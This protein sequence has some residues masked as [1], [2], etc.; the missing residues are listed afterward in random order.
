MGEPPLRLEPVV[1]LLKK[2]GDRPLA[3]EF[4][5]DPAVGRLGR[6]GLGS[7]LAELGM[8]TVIDAGPANAPGQSNPLAW[9]TFTSV[10]APRIIPISRASYA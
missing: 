9:L 4:G 5:R 1:G 3:E 10:D 2:P 8:G 7:V 6:D